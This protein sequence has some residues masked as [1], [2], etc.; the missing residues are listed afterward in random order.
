[1]HT[2]FP[3]RSTEGLP[4]ITSPTDTRSPEPD[5]K[6]SFLHEFQSDELQVPDDR[7]G[8]GKGINRDA[9]NRELMNR[10]YGS[11][12]I[13]MVLLIAAAG[14][15]CISPPKNTS[16]GPGGTGG[17]G[18]NRA[19]GQ[20]GTITPNASG[21]GSGNTSGPGSL[22]QVTP[23][24]MEPIR[25]NP[26]GTHVPSTAGTP[27]MYQYQDIFNKTVRFNYTSLAYAYDLTVPPLYID[28]TMKPDYVTRKIWYEERSGTHKGVTETVTEISPDAWFEFTVRDRKNGEIV[29]SDGFGRQY[30]VR[31]QKRDVIRENGSYQFDMRGNGIEVAIRM[32]V[33]V[34]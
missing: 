27:I 33:M 26:V 16:P 20:T 17:T 30:D 19:P 28:M 29:L 24:G 12:V 13:V 18:S 3:C 6:P 1:M 10:L 8:R 34:P 9:D 14:A 5:K 11:L 32:Q 25:T 15:G 22:Q 23:Y 7:M 4:E 31:T 21:N 2:G